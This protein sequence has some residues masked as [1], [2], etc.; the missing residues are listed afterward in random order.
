[1]STETTVDPNSVD[2]VYPPVGWFATGALACAVVGGILLASYAPRVAPMTVPIILCCLA[3][4]LLL[5]A[6]VMLSRSRPFAWPT[7]FKVFK[8]MLLAYILMAAM[9]ELAF[10]HDHVRGESLVIVTLLLVI[11]ATSVPT[12]GAFTVARYAAIE[13]A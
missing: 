1:M 2:R 7:F 12:I 8:W 4:V 6:V 9:I 3:Y 5:S 11:F 13:D 10:V